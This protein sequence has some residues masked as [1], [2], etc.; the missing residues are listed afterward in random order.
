MTY[1]VLYDPLIP[2]FPWLVVD[3]NGEPALWQPDAKV[4]RLPMRFRTEGIAQ[5]AAEQLSKT[6]SA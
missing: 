2:R 1:R 6:Q 4:G 3:A 5:A